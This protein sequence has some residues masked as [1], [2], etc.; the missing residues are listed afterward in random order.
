MRMIE[1]YLGVDDGWN[2]ETRFTVALG[3]EYAEIWDNGS[4][5]LRMT[6]LER[7]IR[8]NCYFGYKGD[9]RNE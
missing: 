7:W 4:H 1:C 2:S 8:E 5:A 3:D 6:F 9:E